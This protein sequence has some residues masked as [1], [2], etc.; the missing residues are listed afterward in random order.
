MTTIDILVAT[1][2][3]LAFYRGRRRGLRAE[4]ARIVGLLLTLAFLLGF[5]LMSLV[6]NS[7]SALAENLLQ[8]RRIVVSV[9]VLLST[10]FI[11][12]LF[13]IRLR[14]QQKSSRSSEEFPA[15][16]GV[17]GVVRAVLLLIII[18][19]GFDFF[20]PDFLNKAIVGDSVAGQALEILKDLTLKI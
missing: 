4:T 3:G 18:L 2:L 20:L 13:R 5:G 11:V 7:L 9:L 14:R 10:V 17:A 6:G 8:H 12:V 1:Y 16:G 19:L 15:Y